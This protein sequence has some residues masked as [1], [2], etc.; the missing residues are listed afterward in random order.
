MRL[1]IVLAAGAVTAAAFGSSAFAFD[2][3]FKWC[4]GSPA[5]TLKNVPKDV[6]SITFR[7]KDLQA[8]GYQHGGGELT[9]AGQTSVPCG[10]FNKTYSG[11]NPPSGQHIYRWTIEAKDASGKVVAQ[12]TAERPFPER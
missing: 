2:V 12:T 11:P 3:S 5:F 4:S 10:A 8:Y 9:Y 6:I 7:M 1:L